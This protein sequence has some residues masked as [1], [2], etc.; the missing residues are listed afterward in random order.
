[1]F[2]IQYLDIQERKEYEN[3]I[4]KVIEECFKMEGL[5]N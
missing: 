2:E 3:I 5:I 1:M 4:K